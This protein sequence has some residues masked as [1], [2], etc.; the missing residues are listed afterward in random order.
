M[1]PPCNDSGM[2]ELPEVETIRRQLVA[3]LPGDPIVAAWSH[4]S[5]KFADAPLAIGSSIVELDRRGKYL[6]ARLDD[7]RDLIVHLGMTGSLTVHPQAVTPTDADPHLR[8][9]WTFGSAGAAPGGAAPS[10]RDRNSA[11]GMCADSDGSR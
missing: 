2:P 11:S 8:A 3:R 4:P 7:G 10:D 6:I 5:P 9:S 1:R